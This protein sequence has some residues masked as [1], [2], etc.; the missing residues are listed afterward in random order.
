MN[1]LATIMTFY[2]IKNLNDDNSNYDK[3]KENLSIDNFIDFIFKE[4]KE[5]NYV[6]KFSDLFEFLKKY[7]DTQN[8]DV[9]HYDETDQCIST[10]TICLLCCL[11][12]LKKMENHK[13]LIKNYIIN[14]TDSLKNNKYKANDNSNYS[15]Y[16]YIQS[17]F[18]TNLKLKDLQIKINYQIPE[19]VNDIYAKETDYY[20]IQKQ[21]A[22]LFTSNNNNILFH[23]DY[24]NTLTLGFY[25]FVNMN[26]NINNKKEL[27]CDYLKN[28]V[29]L[30]LLSDKVN[31]YDN[32]NYDGF[33]KY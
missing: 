30:N 23:E 14:L 27:V 26:E 24:I 31:L 7:I 22:K 29:G 25:I 9:S 8:I 13:E 3:K 16:E 18:T 15:I 2:Y 28:L 17:F 19:I 12:T 5:S 20:N 11:Q 4:K 33:I 32:P 6:I 21:I 1:N 10:L